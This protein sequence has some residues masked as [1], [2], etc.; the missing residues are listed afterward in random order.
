MLDGVCNPVV[1]IVFRAALK[2]YE[3]GC[4]PAQAKCLMSWFGTY[5]NQ[6]AKS[7]NLTGKRLA[8]QS[9]ASASNTPA[10]AVPH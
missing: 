10:Q 4:K 2:R 6:T 9:P 5:I 8:P 1:S 3:A 7:R